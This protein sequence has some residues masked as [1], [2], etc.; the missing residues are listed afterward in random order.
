MDYPSF[1]IDETDCS[2]FN[3]NTH[4]VRQLNFF[5]FTSSNVLE[6][7]RNIF[8]ESWTFVIKETTIPLLIQYLNLAESKLNKSF[9]SFKKELDNRL[10]QKHANRFIFHVPKNLQIE[11]EVKEDLPDDEDEIWKNIEEMEEEI[12]LLRLK[13]QKVKK[14]QKNAEF[15]VEFLKTFDE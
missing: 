4:I 9:D 8:I 10:F 13:I 2:T 5:Q 7:F 15:Y 1:N 12:I 6:T 3:N 14:K 11:D